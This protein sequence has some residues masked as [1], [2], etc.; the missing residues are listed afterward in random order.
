[1]GVKSYVAGLQAEA[2]GSVTNA[3]ADG[4]SYA[5]RV[6]EAKDK[7]DINRESIAV[8]GK[9]ENFIKELEY[10]R[11]W[12]KYPEKLDEQFAN[13]ESYI[14][15]NDLLSGAAKKRMKEEIL[16]QYKASA[17][18]S[19]TSMQTRSQ[20]AE[21]NVELEGYRSILSSD[22]NT[23]MNDALGKY[24]NHLTDLGIYNDVTVSKMTE[25]FQYSLAPAKAVQDL[26]EAYRGTYAEGDVAYQQKANEIAQEYG[27]DPAQSEQFFQTATSQKDVFDQQIDGMYDA[28]LDNL[29]LQISEAYATGK[30][31]SADS[32]DAMIAEAPDRWKINLRKEKNTVFTNNDVVSENYIERLIVQGRYIGTEDIA[33][34]ES[35]RKPDKRSKMMS[36]DPAEQYQRNSHHR[37]Q[38]ECRDDRVRN[39]CRYYWYRTGTKYKKYRTGNR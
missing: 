25:D 23:S 12:Q 3:L 2:V 5:K 27:L 35:I 10:D 20:M 6:K 21:I 24:R 31:F 32:I 19:I 28:E 1:M 33:I 38:E 36:K 16:P 39:S 37:S 34:A 14:D 15:D 29:H 9:V 17:Q 22:T 7:T 18:N 13:L 30:H 4:L 11:D 26:M 8:Q